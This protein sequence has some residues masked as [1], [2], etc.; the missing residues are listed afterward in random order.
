MNLPGKITRRLDRTNPSLILYSPFDE[1]FSKIHY[2]P[3]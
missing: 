3:S 1:E 2:K